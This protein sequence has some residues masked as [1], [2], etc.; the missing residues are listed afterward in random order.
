MTTRTLYTVLSMFMAVFI[1]AQRTRID[2]LVQESRTEQNDTLRM[3]LYGGLSNSYSELDA[4]S[5]YWY[6]EKMFQ[7]AKKMDLKLE[8]A[9][10]LAEIGYAQLNMANYPRSLQSLL[11]AIVL[12]EDPK[13]ERNVLPPGFP[14]SDEFSNRG[15]APHIQRFQ[16]LARIYQYAG[17][18]YANANYYKKSLFYFEK[19]IGYATKAGNHHLLCIIYV[20][21]GRSYLATNQTDSALIVEQRSLEEANKVGYKR[22]LGSIYLNIGRIYAAKGNK[23]LA[24]QYFKKG[25][26][27]STEFGYYRGI[28]ASDLAIADFFR[29]EG[30]TDSSLH[31]IRSSHPVAEYLMVPDLLL[32]VY[33]AYANYYKTAGD[34]DSAVKYQSFIIKINDS[35]FS[36]KQT[37]QFQN[38]DV[39]EQ[40]RLQH[41]EVAKSVY[42]NKLKMYALLVGLAV[43]LFIALIFW[44]NS[45][46]RKKANALLSWQ[47]KEL[48][49]TL[50]TLKATQS[51][52][53]QSEKM[54]SLGELTA[55]I[56]HEI[57]NPLN[58]V[59]NFSEVNCELI[60]EMKQE[61]DKGKL[62]EIKT[63]A[64]SIDENEQKIIF[65]GKRAD[66]I[67]KGMLQHS[68]SSSGQK[69]L[70]DINTLAD[71]YLRLAYHGLRAKDKSFN[72]TMK[73]DFDESIGKI[74]IIPQEIGRVILNLITNAFYAVTE[75]SASASSAGQTYEPTVTVAT[76]CLLPPLGGSRGASQIKVTDNGNGIPQKV[77]DKIFQ[78]FFTT[79]PT[80]QGTGLGLSLSY[81]IVKAHGG[82]I[83]V[84]TKEN[85]GTEFIISLP[86]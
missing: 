51:Q 69:E 15:A 77:L 80:G 22:Y 64:E 32:R 63:L 59:N 19:A 39:D 20:A 67:V 13:S 7:L 35:L 44:R 73:T 45:Q 74:S 29:Q 66:S 14:V 46:Q 83:I 71:E 36:A 75:K 49:N 6:A 31:Y 30:K 40:Q 43:F 21:M 82:E 84:N 81:D 47:K 50:I 3:I 26:A 48:E 12:A 2:S 68:R 16:K 57:Q 23:H 58:F 79:K 76:K 8:E 60:E 42:R 1:Y 11:S 37:Q 61:I 55:G 56:A 18:L 72:A 28:V 17:I 78:P 70:T 9:H 5:G 41:I 4:D 10:A 34:N 24:F 52:L 53:I 85:E 65:H 33:A 54:A 27:A 86:L 62:A 25:L 38:I